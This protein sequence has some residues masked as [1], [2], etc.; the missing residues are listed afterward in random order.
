MKKKFK[1]ILIVFISL[2]FLAFIFIF[3]TMKKRSITKL[4]DYLYS[5]NCDHVSIEFANWLT[6][7]LSVQTDAG[8]SSVRKGGLIGR[9]YDWYYSEEAEFVVHCGGHGEKY[10]SIGI[11][12]NTEL[13]DSFVNSGMYSPI[14]HFLELYTV[15]GINEKGLVVNTNSVFGDGVLPTTGTNPGGMRLCTA[16]IPRYLLD[17][18]ASV[19]EAISLLQEADLYS[20]TVDGDSFELHFMI[21]DPEKT[22]VVDFIDNN[23]V[24]YYDKNILTNF[25]MNLDDYTDHSVGIER[26]NILTDGYDSISD[27]HSLL[28][29]MKKVWYSKGYELE[30]QWYSDC[31]GY[32]VNEKGEI[33]VHSSNPDDFTDTF[34]KTSEELLPR[35]RDSKCWSTTHTSLY[36]LDAL[37]ITVIPQENDHEYTFRLEPAC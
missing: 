30:S 31:Y 35:T 4:D 8:C 16:L 36:D 29:L 1:V 17:N 3:V 33:F 2:L 21:S 25:Y 13:T 34:L 32:I 12:S 7:K 5:V 9:N 15:D 37:T 20:Y 27:K 24:V 22:A 6:T 18:A 10:S 14:Y 23:L 19:D 11:A 28:E 26:F